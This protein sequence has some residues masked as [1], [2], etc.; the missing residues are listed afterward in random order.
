[1]WFDWNAK[2]RGSWCV[3]ARITG[4]TVGPQVAFVLCIF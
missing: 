3:T 1:M 2:D 4:C